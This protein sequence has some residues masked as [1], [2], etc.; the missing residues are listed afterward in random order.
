MFALLFQKFQR[1]LYKTH[2]RV[3]INGNEKGN[4]PFQNGTGCKL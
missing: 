3:N 2:R 1:T 4:T